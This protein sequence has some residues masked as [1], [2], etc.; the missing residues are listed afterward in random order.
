MEPT[1]DTASPEPGTGAVAPEADAGAAHPPPSETLSAP[2]LVLRHIRRWLFLGVL[3][4]AGI[5]VFSF[6]LGLSS[7]VVFG[8]SNVGLIVLPAAVV[9]G[10]TLASRGARA[11]PVSLATFA[12]GIGGVLALGTLGVYGILL[13]TPSALGVG[14]VCVAV[15]ASALAFMLRSR[16]RV[17]DA[18]VR[19]GGAPAALV[20]GLVLF[21][22]L[23]A[24]PAGRSRT[25]SRWFRASFATMRSDLRNLASA[26]EMH[27]E[28]HGEYAADLAELDEAFLT[29]DGV[30]LL[31]FRRTPDG[32]AA[33]VTHRGNRSTCALF[34]GTTPA[35]PAESPGS[36]ACDDAGR[37]LVWTAAY[38]KFAAMFGFSA[39]MLGMG[40]PWALR[41]P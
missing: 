7:G 1:P 30:E 21:C 14:V 41:R 36:P 35:A 8:L 19:S 32:Y 11:H 25:N 5:F 31:E 16:R 40:V 28:A 39:L 12:S 37:R 2:E 27:R 33:S 15:A 3:A 34:V 26:Q 22:G 20:I 4:G 23:Y 24:L 6:F 18:R 9:V 10:A 17:L 13:G 29:S 38:Q